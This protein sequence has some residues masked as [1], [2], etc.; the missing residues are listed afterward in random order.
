MSTYP[1]NQQ[2]P[3]EFQH[4]EKRLD[5]PD[6]I[7]VEEAEVD[8]A[9]GSGSQKLTPVEIVSEEAVSTATSS[10]TTYTECRA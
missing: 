9:I 3:V 7:E 5:V 4:G 10:T 8:G 2:Q 6:E 1:R